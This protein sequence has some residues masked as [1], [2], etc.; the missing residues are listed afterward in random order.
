VVTGCRDVA[1]CDDA[2]AGVVALA[3]ADGMVVVPGGDA[4]SVKPGTVGVAGGPACRCECAEPHAV[5]AATSAIEIPA[6]V[7][8]TGAPWTTFGTAT[9]VPF[10]S[11]VHRFS[12]GRQEW[13]RAFRLAGMTTSR[14]DELL[15]T[16]QQ[17]FDPGED[18]SLWV[19]LYLDGDDGGIV[20]QVAGPY[21]DVVAAA[22]ALAMIVNETG[23]DHAYVALGRPD[24]RPTEKDRELWRRLREQTTPEVLID[25]AVFNASGALSMREEDAAAA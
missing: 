22:R 25:M 16:L 18:G 13:L 14:T 3:R 24:G 20:N 10:T 15:R 5:T 9:S 17:H 4:D 19:A 23:A 11:L 7:R 8:R 6:A 12:R 2:A 21:E 1:D